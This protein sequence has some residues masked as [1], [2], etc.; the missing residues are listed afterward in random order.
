MRDLSSKTL[1]VC[2]KPCTHCF[3]VQILEVMPIQEI[4]LGSLVEFHE[5][6]KQRRFEKCKAGS[7]KSSPKNM[8]KI[9]KKHQKTIHHP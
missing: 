3:D 7:P 1:E 6:A 4:G 8:Q 9:I 2:H 5:S